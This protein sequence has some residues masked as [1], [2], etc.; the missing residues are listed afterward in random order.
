MPLVAEQEPMVIRGTDALCNVLMVL[1]VLLLVGAD[2][3]G[4]GS[5]TSAFLLANMLVATNIKPIRCD[6]A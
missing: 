4:S 1:E 2:V 3:A 6:S 5:R